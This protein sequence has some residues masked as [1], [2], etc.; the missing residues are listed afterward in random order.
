MGTC[1][2]TRVGWLPPALKALLR[3]E[4]WFGPKS[5]GEN[6]AYNER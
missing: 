1:C 5:G 2:A 3:A 6:A 4:A